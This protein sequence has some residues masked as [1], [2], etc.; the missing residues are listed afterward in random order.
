M[1]QTMYKLG[2]RVGRFLRWFDNHY[3]K[4]LLTIITIA[5][6]YMVFAL[7]EIAYNLSYLDVYVH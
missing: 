6:I 2:R 5:F 1:S 7:I 4:I 3:Y